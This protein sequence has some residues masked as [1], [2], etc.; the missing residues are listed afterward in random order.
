MNTANTI[1]GFY[2]LK[3]Q[4]DFLYSIGDLDISTESLNNRPSPEDINPLIN[5]VHR[6]SKLILEPGIINIKKS[7]FFLLLLNN[8][9]I[10]NYNIYMYV[11][12]V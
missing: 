7:I 3:N 8:G 1:N 12:C 4:P 6:K 5:F 2:Q 9:F 11:L 10:I